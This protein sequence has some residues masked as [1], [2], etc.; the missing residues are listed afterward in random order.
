M[1]LIVRAA[2]FYLGYAL[3]TIVWGGFWALFAWL[4]PY[5][6]RFHVVIGLWTRYCLWWL[7]V[8]CG[9][10]CRID[11][12]ENLP[13]RPCIVLSRHESTWE[14]LFLQT[15]LAP[16]ATLIKRE[17][18]RIPFFGW[19]FRTLRPIA[20]NRK[21][22]R[23]ALRQLIREGGE[24]L[25]NGVWVVLFPEGT[26]L[27]HGERRKFQPGGA[28]LASATGHPIVLVVHDA[29]RFWPAH[30]VLKRPG[31]VQVLISKPIE[32]RGCSTQEVQARVATEFDRLLGLLPAH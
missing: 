30:A 10:R 16:Q 29:G 20:I 24:R 28:A 15:L 26:R 18:L 23:A 14:T 7:R 2:L 9:V 1:L 32:T 6:T 4:L 21:E 11:G 8:T 19:A 17:L 31:T 25:D 12:L 22:P 13:E 5:R 3:V 27:A